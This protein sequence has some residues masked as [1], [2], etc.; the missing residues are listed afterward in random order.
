MQNYQPIPLNEDDLYYQLVSE[1]LQE[2]YLR[3]QWTAI[4][5]DLLFG[6]LP[7]VPQLQIDKLPDNP[8]PR[9]LLCFSNIETPQTQSTTS[10]TSKWSYYL[11]LTNWFKSAYALIRKTQQ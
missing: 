5:R 9:S 2:Q 3:N 1:E 8:D 11:L 10:E 4:E 6:K 7:D